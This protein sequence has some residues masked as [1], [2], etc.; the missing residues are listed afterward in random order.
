MFIDTFCSFV[1]KVLKKYFFNVNKYFIFFSLNKLAV[2]PL[3]PC[4]F[5]RLLFFSVMCRYNILESFLDIHMYIF[6][7]FLTQNN[8]NIRLIPM[9][10]LAHL[11]HLFNKEH[12][13]DIHVVQAGFPT[14]Q[15][16][17]SKGKY[18]FNKRPFNFLLNSITQRLPSIRVICCVLLY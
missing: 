14:Y 10:N 5:S 12:H 2:V 18:R 17:H 3:P 11:S 15:K 1:T 13:N 4:C 8:W 7:F 6:L 16:Q 9:N